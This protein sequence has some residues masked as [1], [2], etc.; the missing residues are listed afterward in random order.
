MARKNENEKERVETSVE[1]WEAGDYGTEKIVYD[2]DEA[3][4]EVEANTKKFKE[5]AQKRGKI[6]NKKNESYDPSERKVEIT[7]KEGRRFK[8]LGDFGEQLTSGIL[9]KNGFCEIIDLNTKMMNFPFADFS[10]ERNSIKY[11]ISVKSRNKY[12]HTGK[13]NSRYKLGNSEKTLN[14]IK[15]EEKYSEYK[16]YEPAWLAIS[17]EKKTFDAYFGTI[18]MLKNKRGI[19]MS[20]K[21]L[22]KY[23]NLSLKENHCFDSEDF[24]NIYNKKN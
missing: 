11:I 22:D 6:K 9:A 24:I 21:H 7:K 16:D 12:E 14:K 4:A 20:K 1:Y 5:E 15:T 18:E 8:K 17:F 2:S 13:L 19:S 23:E 10:A 3:N